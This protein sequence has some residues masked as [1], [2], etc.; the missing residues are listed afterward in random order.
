M[1]DS[2]EVFLLALRDVVEASGGMA[3]LA[4]KSSLNRENLYRSLSRK[5]NFKPS[6]LAAILDAVGIRLYFIFSD[7]LVGGAM[8]DNSLLPMTVENLI[9]LVRGHKVMLDED[10]ARLYDVETRI[11]TRAVRRN[12]DRFPPDFMFQLSEPEVINLRSQSGISSSSYG[13]RRYRPLVFT[14]QGIAMLSTVLRS[15]KAVWVNIEIMRAFVKLRGFIA[16]NQEL[17]RKLAELEQR[18]DRQF[19]VVFDAIR[20]L[21]SP[22]EP[23]KKRRIGF[24]GS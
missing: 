6:S 16:S 10:L 17:A 22:A 7:R 18:Y 11:L 5:G 15:K 9:Y 19:K 24:G 14:E 8:A 3:N 13:G 4:R 20:E 12:A 1:S 23:P 21:M 2:K